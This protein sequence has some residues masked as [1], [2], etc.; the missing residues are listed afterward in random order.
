LSGRFRDR[1]SRF[2]RRDIGASSGRL[3]RCGDRDSGILSP[4]LRDIVADVVTDVITEVVPD[5]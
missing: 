4:R 5:I 2:S 1:F 3:G